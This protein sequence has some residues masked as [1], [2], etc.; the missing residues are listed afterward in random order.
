MTMT[1]HN[2][3][4]GGSEQEDTWWFGAR[5]HLVVRSNKRPGGS[6][7]EDTWWFGLKQEDT[8]WFGARRHLVVQSNQTLGGSEQEDTWWF[9]ARRHLVVRSNKTLSPDNVPMVGELQ[10]LTYCITKYNSDSFATPVLVNSVTW[11]GRSRTKAKDVFTPLFQTTFYYPFRFI[12][13]CTT[14]LAFNTQQIDKNGTR[15]VWDD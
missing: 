1:K 9:G 3:T 2:K 12:G 14:M 11:T 7:Q 5:R 13:L 8:W 4:P 10:R 15:A 6:E